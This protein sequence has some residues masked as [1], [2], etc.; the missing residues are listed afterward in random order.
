MTFQL[1]PSFQLVEA[2]EGDHLEVVATCTLT[3]APTGTICGV[4]PGSC[5]TRESKYAY[6]KGERLCPKCGA[7]A[8]IKGQEQ[9]GGGWVCWKKKDGCG[10]KFSDGDDAIESQKTDRVENPDLP[11]QWN[12]VRKMA[13]KRAHVAA[14]L[15]AT[16][17]SELFTQD[18]EDMAHGP[19]AEKSEPRAVRSSASPPTESEM[20]TVVQS[21]RFSE[22]ME[23]LNKVRADNRS[24]GWST[25][26]Q[27]ALNSAFSARKQE[28]TSF[29]PA[30]G[31]A[32]EADAERAAIQE[33]S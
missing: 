16:G 22:S 24:R 19:D 29:Y 27:R 20:A 18:V 3:H 4:A 1:S 30:G 25:A 26:Q 15:F 10:A 23:K 2:K 5:S 6:R 8:I 28:L 33:E 7:A 13:C 17:A 11:D 14:T 31:F 32:D 9:Y 21:M 12:T